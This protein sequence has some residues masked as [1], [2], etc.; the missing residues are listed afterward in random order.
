VGWFWIIVAPA[1]LLAVYSLRAERARARYWTE[2]LSQTNG[3]PIPP[4]TVIVPV[5]GEDEGLR[6][7]LAA[8]ASLDYPDYELIVAARE[9][10]DI[11]A[12]AVPPNARVVLAGDGDPGTGGKIRNLLAAVDAARPGSQIFAFAD[13]DGRVTKNWLRSLAG[14]AAGAGAA[15]GYRWYLP[16]PPDFWSLLRGVWN[17]VI[18]EAFRPAGA[19]F[20]WGGS[21][22]IRREIFQRVRVAE[23]WKGSVSDDY[24]LSRAVRSAGLRIAF[25]PG[26]LVPCVDHVS[27]GEFLRWAR[28]QLVLTRVYQPRLWWM[29]L[30]ATASY[31]A[32]M[33]ACIAA[34]IQGSIAG[35]YTLVAILFAGMLKGANRAALAR[36]ALPQYESWFKRYGWVHTWWVPL[37]TWTWLATLIASA[38]G[39]AI[40]WRGNRY[41]L[42]AK[43]REKR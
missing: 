39:N 10:D 33:A 9:A 18:V 34:A 13:S 29:G 28:R 15:T 8:L 19:E 6:E 37:A 42:Q 22:A 43:N 36:R 27:G 14:A 17:A 41:S 20:A 7:N 16:D 4:A 31:C 12:G 30:V 25:A 40:E 21:M 23:F 32:A 35:E 1:L 5:K 38:R 11:P 3:I 24:E 26:A 2:S